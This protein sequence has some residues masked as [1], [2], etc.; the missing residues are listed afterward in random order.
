MDSFSA[1]II[2]NCGL[3]HYGVLSPDGF[4]MTHGLSAVICAVE[5]LLY[6]VFMDYLV[7]TIL[8]ME[9]LTIR[10]LHLHQV[11]HQIYTTWH[12]IASLK[13]VN[14]EMFYGRSPRHIVNI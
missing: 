13:V 1:I 9:D 6:S 2:T 14:V 8:T 3:P 7:S 5:Y 10:K 4:T 12:Y 11:R